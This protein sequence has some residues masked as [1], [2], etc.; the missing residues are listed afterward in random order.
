MKN[1][2]RIIIFLGVLSV[3]AISFM[4]LLNYVD[5]PSVGS[6]TNSKITNIVAPALNM[7]PTLFS[8]QYASFDY[9]A[10]LK[11]DH[12]NPSVNPVV[13]DYLFSYNDIESWNLAISIYLIP[14]GELVDNNSYQVREIHTDQYQQST[15]L[16][17]DHNVIIMTDK[18]ITYYNKVAFLVRG[19]YQATISLSGDDQG[20]EGNLVKTLNMILGSWTWKTN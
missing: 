19:S 6:I 16:I 12:K 1:K 3:L 8:S 10:I 5:K 14:A 9:P 4:I 18:T 7:T 11:K 20:G 15:Q 13:D 17:N 2:K